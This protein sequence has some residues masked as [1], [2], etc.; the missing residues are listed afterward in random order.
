MIGVATPGMMPAMPEAP[1]IRHI[2]DIPAIPAGGVGYRLVR[3]ALGITAFGVNAFTADAGEELIE[4]HDETTSA[5]GGH[6][7]LYV[8]IAG[9]A[10]FEIDGAEHDAP[11]GTLVFL[12]DPRSR[13][14][15]TAL[16]D[17][18]TALA[19][20]GAPGRPYEVSAWEQ[21]FA[22]K[23]LADAGDPA[24]AADLMA[25]VLADH[26]D[27][28]HVLYNT[29]CFEALA[30]RRE[31]ALAHLRAAAEIAPETREWAAG[32]SDFDAIRDDPEFP[33]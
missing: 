19:V 21:A 30:G 15:A 10:R 28:A 22:A 24:A 32:D 13:R 26:P 23:S 33:A 20:G 9:H 5:A 12:P 7:E 31:D 3:R 8:V 29:A 18:T 27:N 2:E 1:R 14:S 4:D 17:G 11:A 16:A 25:P 6:E